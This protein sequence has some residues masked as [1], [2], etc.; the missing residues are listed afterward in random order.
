[1]ESATALASRI[2]EALSV[3]YDLDHDRS[4]QLGASVGIALAPE[5]EV[6]M[7]CLP[8]RTWPSMQPRLPAKEQ[9]HVFSPDMETR[10]QD[11]VRLETRLRDALE[12]K[13]GLFVFY[14]PIVSIETGKVT[15]REARS[16]ASSGTRLDFAGRVHPDR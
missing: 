6:P 1:M 14:Q 5:H 4:I 12:T 7:R 9:A 3:P 15:A 11:R 16:L 13:D 8:A 10:V 2:I